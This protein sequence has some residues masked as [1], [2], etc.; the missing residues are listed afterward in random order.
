L[1]ERFPIFH[2]AA[3]GRIQEL[4]VGDAAPEKKRQA[5]GQFKVADAVAG[6]GRYPG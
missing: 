5:G 1:L 2:L 4:V 6:A 3:F